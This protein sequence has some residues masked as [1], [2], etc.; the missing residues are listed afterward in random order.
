MEKIYLISLYLEPEGSH[1][2]FRSKIGFKKYED[3]KIVAHTIAKERNLFFTID[4][5][6]I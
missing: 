4:I 3:A 6:E 5:I 1:C 2:V